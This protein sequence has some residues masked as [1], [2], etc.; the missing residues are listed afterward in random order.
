MSARA[1]LF[2][3]YLLMNHQYKLAALGVIFAVT[4]VPSIA[5]AETDAGATVDAGAA[6]ETLVAPRDAASGQATG[7]VVAPR[8]VATG[9][10]SGKRQYQPA[11]P[12]ASTTVDAE[13]EARDAVQMRMK[14][15]AEANASTSMERREAAEKQ[16]MEVRSEG[17]RAL[18]ER[19]LT[20][21]A[22]ALDR[23]SGLTDRLESRAT[24][25][26]E[27]GVN[28][29]A[30]A[31]LIASARAKIAEGRTAIADA[32]AALDASADL[33]ADP[34]CLDGATGTRCAPET[35]QGNQGLRASLEKA[36][37]A[38]RAA[39]KALVDALVSLKASVKVEATATTTVGSATTSAQ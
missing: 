37:S 38:V 33:A 4:M 9:Q 12:G 21:L 10:S 16:M 28:V 3:S 17:R 2:S 14:M 5:M 22:A 20:R 6:A 15:N 29:S 1:A 7:K 8:D 26:S 11:Q 35:S 32:R 25:M 34:R 31:A 39:H 24:K 36:N 19:T 27:K 23:L 13:I 30:T 18:A